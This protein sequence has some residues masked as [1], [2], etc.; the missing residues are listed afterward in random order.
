[1]WDKRIHFDRNP[2]KR[3]SKAETDALKVNFP[4]NFSS[5]IF[6]NHLL[7]FSECIQS[8]VQELQAVK[9]ETPEFVGKK[10]HVSFFFS[11]I[12]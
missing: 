10:I 12:K 6:K 9:E 3:K 7:E 4:R 8:L 5:L 2:N 1:M 11:T